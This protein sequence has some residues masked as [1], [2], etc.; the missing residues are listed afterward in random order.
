[1][2]A[3]RGDRVDKAD[4]TAISPSKHDIVLFEGWMLGFTPTSQQLPPSSNRLEPEDPMLV[5]DR[6]L[7]A[8]RNVHE[9]FDSWIVMAVE[10]IDVVYRWRLQAEQQMRAQG[11]ASLTDQQVSRWND[12]STLVDHSLRCW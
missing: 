10:D 3:G 11:K 5:I 6:N 2:R 4:W 7:E 12:V 1:M 8:Y 9:I